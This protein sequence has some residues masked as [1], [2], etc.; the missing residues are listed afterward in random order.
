MEL[1][2][3]SAHPSQ[4]PKLEIVDGGLASVAEARH[5]AGFVMPRFFTCHDGPTDKKTVWRK[6]HGEVVQ[7]QAPELELIEK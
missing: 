4:R 1:I 7:R 5:I 2:E 6:N 3:Q